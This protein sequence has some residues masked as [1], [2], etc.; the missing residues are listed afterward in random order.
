[1]RYPFRLGTTSYIIP[2]DI[3]PNAQYLADKVQDIELVLFEVDDGPNNLPSA[4]VIDELIQLAD[5][6]QLTYT[7]HLPL[8]LRLGAG[9]DEQ[10]VSL[11]KARKVIEHTRALQP[12]AYVMHLDGREVKDDPSAGALRRWQDQSCRALE[13][14]AEWAGGADRLAVENLESYPLNFIAPV[15]DRIPVARCVDIGHLWLD[16]HDPVP[17][18]REALPRTR[19]I[20]LHGI[21]EHDHKSLAQ[22][23]REKIDAVLACLLREK[24]AGVLTLEIFGEDDFLSSM[25]V[26]EQSAR[27]IWASA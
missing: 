3:L 18:L 20:H 4:E 17:Y 27:S 21:A 9:G 6:H 1:M 13:L 10:H 19:V 2:A 7:V 24:Y 14:V 11:I 15:V 12:W 5:Q 25:V 23:P 26:L 8:D 22:Q 16:G